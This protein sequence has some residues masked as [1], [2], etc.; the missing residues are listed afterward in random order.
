MSD[1]VTLLFTASHWGCSRMRA[2]F[3]GKR[4]R[5]VQRL[6]EIW[7]LTNLQVP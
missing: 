6:C 2:R 5:A 1:G 4:R 3:T 7:Q